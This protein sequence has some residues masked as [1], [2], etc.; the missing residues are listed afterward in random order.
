[1]VTA[2]GRR[3]RKCLTEL[4]R[5]E[6]VDFETIIFEEFG[7]GKNG[8][9]AHSLMRTTSHYLDFRVSTGDLADSIRPG[10]QS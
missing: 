3:T 1:M 7:H 8:A 2:K 4:P 6:A 10:R 9:I 5:K